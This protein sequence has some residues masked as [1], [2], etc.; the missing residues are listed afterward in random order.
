MTTQER[1]MLAKLKGSIDGKVMVAKAV[2]RAAFKVL[3]CEEHDYGRGYR[4]HSRRQSVRHLRDLR[5]VQRT[6]RE[7]CKGVGYHVQETPTP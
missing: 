2:V 3:D 7:Y 4:D 1:L 6:V 5:D